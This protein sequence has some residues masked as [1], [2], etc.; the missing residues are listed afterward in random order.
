M[1][2]KLLNRGSQITENCHHLLITCEAE[3]RQM[4]D[5]AN[6][7]ATTSDS[8]ERQVEV[9]ASGVPQDL[10]K[11]RGHMR[12]RAQVVTWSRMLWSV[13]IVL[14]VDFIFMFLCL[15]LVLYIEGYFTFYMSHYLGWFVLYPWCRVNRDTN[16]SVVCELC[17]FVI[18]STVRVWAPCVAFPTC[19]AHPHW[20]AVRFV[21]SY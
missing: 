19:G 20:F 6:N 18:A 21:P 11:L 9:G 14:I 17:N 12:Q 16:L 4:R 10:R 5:V 8:W 15:D 1:A 3:G 2:A 7:L 13:A